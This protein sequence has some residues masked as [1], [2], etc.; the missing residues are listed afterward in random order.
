MDRSWESII[1]KLGKIAS[2]NN[3]DIKSVFPHI[4]LVSEEG[5]G[6]EEFV[7]KYTDIVIKGN[8]ISNI[9]K[10]HPCLKLKFPSLGDR[11][12]VDRF[13]ASPDICAKDSLANE[14]KGVFYIDMSDIGSL[15]DENVIRLIEYINSHKDKIK[16]IL[17]VNPSFN[18]KSELIQRLKGML[19]EKVVVQSLDATDSVEYI[20][21]RLGDYSIEIDENAEAIIARK[22]E[23]ICE[24]DN[25]S[26]YKTLE[27][28]IRN[29][30]KESYDK[31]NE[32]NSMISGDDIVNMRDNVFYG[33]EHNKRQVG[34]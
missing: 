29:I 2:S 6:E 9:N 12:C 17:H 16:F 13:F 26:N 33:L 3:K 19:I 27:V 23:A 31:A 10:K 32:N 15:F 18:G 7:R 21:E 34:F 30:I 20:K 14:Y 25:Y 24:G 5:C 28:I 22:I 1:Q 4:L 11:W 8:I